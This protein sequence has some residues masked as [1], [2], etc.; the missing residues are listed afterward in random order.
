MGKA[1]LQWMA[2][3][4]G[5]ILAAALAHFTSGAPLT[6][7]TLLTFVGAAVLVRAANWVIA[8]LGPKPVV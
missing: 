5:G 2:A 6:F 7:T 4:V 8:F 1:F 3:G